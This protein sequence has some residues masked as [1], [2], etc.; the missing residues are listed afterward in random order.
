MSR[1]GPSPAARAVTATLTGRLGVVTLL[2]HGCGR[3]ADVAHYRSAGLDADGYD[4]HSDFGWPRPER[5]G[6]DLVTQAF[7]LNVLPNP[8]ERVRALQDAASFVR[9]GGHVLVVT[10]SPEEITK[11]AATGGWARHQDGFWSS[12]G[13]VKVRDVGA[14]KVKGSYDTKLP[15]VALLQVD[16]A[17][18]AADQLVRR[19][20]GDV[21]GRGVSRVD[22]AVEDA[23]HRTW[24]DRRGALR[25]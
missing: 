24:S 19:D 21:H 14:G 23:A 25:D 7:V 16:R 12:E 3:G 13:H 6:Y 11:A 17:L 15:G 8:W 22:Q 4:P 5:G 20:A 10:R 18:E 2:D 9:P 1:S